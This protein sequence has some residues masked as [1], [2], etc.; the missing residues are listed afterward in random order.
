MNNVL[1]WLLVIFAGIN[2]TIGNY[3]LKKSQ[4]NFDTFFFSILSFEFLTGCTFYVFNVILFS[5][6]LKELEVSKAYPV[7]ASISFITLIF[8]SYLFLNEAISKT[9]IFGVFLIIVG[10]VFLSR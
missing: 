1:S 5:Y 10:I 4:Q 7:L 2:S 9:K 8:L 3:F 6:S